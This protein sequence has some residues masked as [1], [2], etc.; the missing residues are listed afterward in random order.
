[1]MATK[2]S[3]RPTGT[4]RAAIA[5]TA[6]QSVT[7]S[8]IESITHERVEIVATLPFVGTETQ[9]HVPLSG[10]PEAGFAV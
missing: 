1:M 8:R 9:K 5:T 7:A 4:N 2:N 10:V 6:K 3:G